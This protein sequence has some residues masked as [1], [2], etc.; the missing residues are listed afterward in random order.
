[1]GGEDAFESSQQL[2]GDVKYSEDGKRYYRKSQVV[3][4]VLLIAVMA[5]VVGVLCAVLPACVEPPEAPEPSQIIGTSPKE[6][7]QGPPATT[8]TVE[9]PPP[10]PPATTEAPPCVGDWCELRL[11]ETLQADHY[12]LRLRPDLAAETYD[13]DVVIEITVT[14]NIKYPRIHYKELTITNTVVRRTDG[15][16]LPIVQTFYYAPNEFH[17]IEMEEELTPGNYEI[18][19][20]FTNSLVGK[21]VGFY[22]SIYKNAANE[23]R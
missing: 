20:H 17:V 9:T 16:V 18:E 23:E 21:I 6:P 14:E 7:T 5:T 2:T 10:E 22:K 15:T 8:T 13:G 11:P 1:M 4:W 19:L 3:A 12:I